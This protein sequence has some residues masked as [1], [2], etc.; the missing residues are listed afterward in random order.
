MFETLKSL[1]GRNVS[2]K[3]RLEQLKIS[4]S[5]EKTF[6]AAWAAE[7]SFLFP[8]DRQEYQRENIKKRLLCSR[9]FKEKQQE[10][11]SFLVQMVPEIDAS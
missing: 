3:K 10:Q 5:S 9:V 6:D 2:T 11:E 1:V 4:L 7:V 8:K